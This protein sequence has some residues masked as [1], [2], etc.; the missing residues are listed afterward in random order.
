M[1]SQSLELLHSKPINI[2]HLHSPQRQQLHSCSLP[3]TFFNSGSDWKYPLSVQWGNLF[4]C[5]TFP[6]NNVWRP[7]WKISCPS[8]VTLVPG[9]WATC[10]HQAPRC[11]VTLCWPFLY[12][13][14]CWLSS[15][16]I[17]IS[18]NY[19]FFILWTNTHHILQE[20]QL[21]FKLLQYFPVTP[22]TSPFLWLSSL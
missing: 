4:C 14:W 12:V 11:R 7:I 16:C 21:S 10:N 3:I 8:V 5:S 20:Y 15:H 6:Q 9:P 2:L 19:S 22:S 18:G 17:F 1:W 13:V